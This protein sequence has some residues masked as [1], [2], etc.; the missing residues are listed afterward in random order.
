MNDQTFRSQFRNVLM[1]KS[2][3]RNSIPAQAQVNW[4][5]SFIADS[6]IRLYP[7]T[8]LCGALAWV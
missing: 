5:F 7:F 6:S 8:V 1:K 2:V 4:R 3:T